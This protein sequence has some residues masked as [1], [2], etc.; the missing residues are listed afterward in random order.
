MKELTI[1][2]CQIVSGGLAPLVWATAGVATYV[3]NKIYSGEKITA[4]GIA[5]SAAGG[6]IGGAV[7]TIVRVS[8]SLK[9]IVGGFAGGATEGFISNSYQGIKNNSDSS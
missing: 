1:R 2:D 6:G 5:S 7:S 8:S 3:G 4:L 9:P